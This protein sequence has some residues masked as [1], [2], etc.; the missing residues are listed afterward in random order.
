M[1]WDHLD[2]DKPHLAYMILGGFT[3]LFM[4]CS[5]FVKEKLYIGEASVATICGIIFGPHAAN[6]FN[7]LSW[8]NVDK[9][10]LECSRIVLVVQCFAVGVELP[11]AYMERHWKS[12]TLL[13]LPVMTWGWLVTSLFIWWLIEP[14]TWLEA[15]VCAACVTAT[16]PVLASSVVG[17]GK[18]AKRVPRHLR[19]LLSA[20]SGCNDGMAFP[21]IY[22][23]YYILHY[24]PDTNEV[25]LHWFCVTI[26]YECVFGAI[27]GFTIGYAA[28]HAIRFAERKQLID[29]ESFL[30]FYF[31]LALFCAGS[32]SLLGMD[33]LLIGFAAGVGFSNDGWFTEKTEESHVSNV[34][35]LLLNLAYFVYLG[36]I[37]PW[38][39]FNNADIGLS[40]WR[41]V[42]IAILVIFFRRIP[43][44]LLLKPII[45]DV[46]TWREALFAGHF[47]PIGVGAIFAC[48]LAR[49]ELETGTTQP[50]V[51]ADFPRPHTHNYY[52]VQ[53]IWPLTT[54]LV[55]SSILVH[56]SSI[57]V[58]TL[59]KRINTLSI[60]LSYTQANEEGPSW[61]NRLPRVQSLAKGSMSF[62]KADDSEGSSN[63]PEYPPGT[64]P[65]IGLPGNFLRRQQEDDTNSPIGKVSSRRA[66]R[67]RRKDDGAGGP[68]SQSAIAP[69]RPSEVESEDAEK[70]VNETDS[71][72]SPPL[73]KTTTTVNVFLEGTNLIFE[74]KDGNVLK[75]EHIGHMSPEEQQ[76]HLESER[77]KLNVEL[78]QREEKINPQGGQ[79]P[80][81]GD[82]AEQAIGEKTGHP[83]EKGR[84]R[85]NKW[86]GPGKKR[87]E[88][89]EKTGKDDE[90][91]AQKKEAKTPKGKGRSA[92]AYQFGNTIIVEDE[93]GEV[94]K[95]YSIPAND[96][97]EMSDPVRR[98]LT[99]MG[100]WFGQEEEGE[101][102]QT[103][104]KTAADE[105]LAD[106]GL[107]FTL[108]NDEEVGKRGVNHKGRR[109]T[110][111]EF[112]ERLRGLGPKARQSVV[113]ETDVPERV[114]DVARD[115]ARDAAH[116][117]RR[118]STPGVSSATHR[119][120]QD[121][122]ESLSSVSDDESDSEVPGHNVAASLARIAAGTA[123]EE[124][125]NDLNPST[126]P[127]SPR[128]TSPRKRRDSEDDGTERVPPSQLREAA[129]L[130]SPPQQ[131]DLDDTSETPAERRRRLAALGQV[132]D[133]DDSDDDGAIESDTEDNNLRQN[134]G[135]ISF[136]DGTKLEGGN[137]YD[138]EGNG[139][140]SR[141]HRRTSSRV[142][143]GGEKGRDS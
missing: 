16:D 13:L 27:F 44:M 92:H 84:N 21:F 106:D 99:R 57:A 110:K 125:R 29:R 38:E 107:R 94:I 66:R 51:E 109:M 98:G 137:T 3:G 77:S 135:K 52:I 117:E 71:T 24:R 87:A 133:S 91:A 90:E 39:D 86:F 65:P 100:T 54:F 31:V 128:Q 22:L 124:R 140:S 23:S 101:A 60:T 41:L 104:K 8:G 14:L 56:G 11:K 30:V 105:W 5:L 142:S 34:I 141:S 102:S 12:V 122:L 7:P 69:L 37:V 48:I 70:A 43:I 115:E 75:T 6:L 17:K 80:T 121:D 46:K 58:F 129:G 40:A 113:E 33:D 35:D 83:V 25:A 53:I 10:T 74:D 36:A 59:G 95:K 32:G 139:M 26:L 93:D 97:P 132:E 62:R 108:A 143:W 130:L 63:E 55:I 45:P 120:P 88:D 114:K 67:R 18:F 85:F 103:T 127:L 47:G 126:S 61:M 81:P 2:I 19:D 116:Q 123:A 73:H 64:L 42:V 50:V 134:A 78:E 15:L 82:K 72:P 79:S 4:L 118:R 96:K 89:D 131:A 136:A 76:Q 119:Q 1:A 112:A 20:E 111:Q 9:I 28:R 138:R 68:I 49:A